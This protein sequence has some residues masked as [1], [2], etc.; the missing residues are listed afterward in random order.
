MA[1]RKR[2]EGGEVDV[3]EEKKMKTDLY[4]QNFLDYCDK[5]A[6]LFLLHARWYE[7]LFLNRWILRGIIYRIKISELRYGDYR[8]ADEYIP[9][10]SRKKMLENLGEKPPVM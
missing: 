9:L 2:R 4:K 5:K 6:Q 1:R 8:Q 3:M 10:E 7:R